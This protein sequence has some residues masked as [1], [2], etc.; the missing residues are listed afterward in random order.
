[1]VAGWTIDQRVQQNNLD[2]LQQ[3]TNIADDRA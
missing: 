2:N 1:M 3:F